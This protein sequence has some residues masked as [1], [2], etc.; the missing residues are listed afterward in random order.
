MHVFVGVGTL[1][2][3]HEALGEEEYEIVS[4]CWLC[5]PC[6]SQLHFLISSAF[7]I[8]LLCYLQLLLKLLGE[9]SILVT[10]FKIVGQQGVFRKVVPTP[11][12]FLME[13]F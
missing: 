3:G 1:M 5:C 12:Y 6:P 9:V 7:G 8:L 13:Q 2:G 11:T 4:R 10:V